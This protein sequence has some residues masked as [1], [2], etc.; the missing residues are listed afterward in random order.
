MSEIID[1]IPDSWRQNF[2]LDEPLIDSFQY[3]S[4]IPNTLAQ[5]KT[6]IMIGIDEAGRGK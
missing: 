2:K 5:F 4:P 3:D 6:P 1:E